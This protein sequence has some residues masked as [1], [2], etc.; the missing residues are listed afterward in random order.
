MRLS[1][2]SL[3]VVAFFVAPGAVLSAQVPAARSADSNGGEGA[4]FLLV[5]V[6][7]R[8]AALGQ[9]AVADG[10]RSEAAFWNPAGLARMRSG[11]F[12]IHHASTF[13]S[14]NTAVALYLAANRLGVFGAS[15][16]LVDYGTQPVNPGPGNAIGQTSV[17]NVELLASYATLLGPRVG[18]GLNYKLVQLR[19]ECSGDCTATPTTI[20]TTHAVDVGL[21]YRVGADGDLWLGAALQHA[22][23]K[24]QLNNRDQADRL[25][26]RVQ[27]GAVYT[28]RLPTPAGVEQG[29]DARLLVDVRQAWGRV[30]NPDL[31]VGLDL[32]VGELL[33]LRAGYAFLDAENSGPAIGLGLSVGRISIDFAQ[34]F[35]DTAS[36]DEPVHFTLR[37]QL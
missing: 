33:R 23:F 22:G 3:L 14:D 7:G 34:V 26:A 25:P 11:E 24:L 2:S 27:L 20:G 37:A 32:G 10:G 4:L 5:P 15:A 30:A 1:P 31:R 8:A 6:G 29:I 19:H 21:Q 9:A 35:F 36:L 17:K 13:I 28:V 16:Y 12:A 18:F